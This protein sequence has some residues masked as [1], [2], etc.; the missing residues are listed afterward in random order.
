MEEAAIH[1]MPLLHLDGYLFGDL[2]RTLSERLLVF[3]YA[4]MAVSMLSSPSLFRKHV[5]RVL[6]K[7]TPMTLGKPSLVPN[8]LAKHSKISYIA[9]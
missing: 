1:L 2:C 7:V 4:A 6:L 3:Y 5:V 8:F 9:S